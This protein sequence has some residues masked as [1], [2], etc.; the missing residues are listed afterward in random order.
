MTGS[1]PRKV[2]TCEIG[3][4]AREEEMVLCLYNPG[5]PSVCLSGCQRDG[6]HSSYVVSSNGDSNLYSSKNQ[7]K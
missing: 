1:R 2:V 4:V 7:I 6:E 3:S 5:W